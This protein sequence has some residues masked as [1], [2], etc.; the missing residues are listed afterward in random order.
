MELNPLKSTTVLR[1]LACD[2]LHPWIMFS[3]MLD[4]AA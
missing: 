4:H 2:F 3:Q 1:E